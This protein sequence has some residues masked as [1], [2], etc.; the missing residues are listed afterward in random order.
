MKFHY[1]QITKKT[2]LKHN[3]Y[4]GNVGHLKNAYPKC[5]TTH[6]NGHS[7]E[8]SLQSDKHIYIYL[9]YLPWERW[10]F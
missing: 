2:T 4:H 5:T 7:C 3:G 6:P 8:V 1:N 10:P 9:S